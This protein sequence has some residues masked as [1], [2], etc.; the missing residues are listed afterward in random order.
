MT[1]VIAG[2][3]VSKA[4]LDVHVD[5]VDRTFAND[6]TGFRAPGTNRLRRS[7]GGRRP[8]GPGRVAPPARSPDPARDGASGCRQRG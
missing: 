7:K 5:G 6:R 1:M 4:V 8:H 3:D 2:V